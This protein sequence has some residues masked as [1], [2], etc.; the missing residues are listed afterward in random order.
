MSGPGEVTIV[1]NLDDERALALAQFVKRLTWG[2]M[3]GCAVDDDEARDIR[4]AVAFLQD[5]LRDAG[6]A[7]R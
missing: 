7:P 6:Y 5:A 4:T 2:D 3:R 1:F